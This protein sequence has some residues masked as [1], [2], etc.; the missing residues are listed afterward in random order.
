MSTP[1]SIG[2]GQD[3]NSITNEYIPVAKPSMPFLGF[4][5]GD[6][7]AINFDSNPHND[8]CKIYFPKL[9]AIFPWYN[10]TLIA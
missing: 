10:C 5:N 7:I 1:E 4:Q 2:L 3:I 8:V 9:H 6:N